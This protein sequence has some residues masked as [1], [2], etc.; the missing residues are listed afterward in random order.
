MSKI[1]KLQQLIDEID[2]LIEKRVDSSSIDFRNW[3]EQV[4]YFLE[5]QYG[6]NSQEYKRF[7]SIRFAPL[8]MIYPNSL[9]ERDYIE[10]CKKDLIIQ[11]T[12]FNLYLEELQ[13]QERHSETRIS[14]SQKEFSFTK[15]FIVH[16]HDEALKE[17]IARLIEKQ[18]I[19]AI[20][21]DEQANQ[22][23]TIIEKFEENSDV[24]GAICLFT[25]DDVGKKKGG[26]IEKARA[27]QNVVFETG[28]FMGKLGRD[29]VVIIAEHEMEFPSDLSGIVYSNKENWEFTVLKELKAMGYSIDMNKVC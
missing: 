6:T 7:N 19:E 4:I 14:S 17:K 3:H 22:G 11:K 23:R 18:D 12:R 28:Y 21:L 29:H 2:V 10:H 27:R 1:E 15:V 16:G 26:E 25:A 24:G 13:E 5:K 9:T 8:V 20:I